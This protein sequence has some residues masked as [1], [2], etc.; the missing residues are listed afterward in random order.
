[1]IDDFENKEARSSGELW[2]EIC[3]T[4][5]GVEQAGHGDEAQP[6]FTDSFH[7]SSR[8]GLQS[9]GI[10]A[11]SWQPMEDSDIYIAS[12]GTTNI[13]SSILP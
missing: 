6:Q 11:V 4:L 1:M 5:P 7:P 2:S 9:N 10:S 3:S 12:L 8:I 13:I